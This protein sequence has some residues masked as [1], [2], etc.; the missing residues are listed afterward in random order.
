M[1]QTNLDRYGVEYA[2][3]SD[4][5]KEKVKQTNIKKY[6]V[7]Y[8][9]QSGEIKEKMKQT[10][11]DRYG[12]EN[13]SQ[14]SDI[15]KKKVQTCIGNYGVEN[16][17]QS[18][19]I[20]QKKVQTCIDKYGY[21]NYSHTRLSEDILSK[22]NNHAWLMEQYESGG[23]KFISNELGISI[24]T[25]NV[26]LRETSLKRSGSSFEI[27]IRSF[28]ESLGISNIVTND[29]KILEG[30]E[31]DIYL[32]DQKI[33]IECNGSYWHSELQ[34]KPRQYHIEKTKI[35]KSEGIHLIHIWH[36]DWISNEELIKS[37][38]KSK[39]GCNK[40]VYARKCIISAITAKGATEFMQ[41]NHIQGS[42]PGSAR[43][44]LFYD[45]E[46][47]AL[48]T[49]GKSRYKKDVEYELLRYCSKQGINVVGG[50]SKLFR[51][52]IQWYEPK[53]I[54]SYSDRM[55]N[56]G[57]LYEQLGFVHSHSTDPAY[58]YT[59]DYLHFE[60]RVAY[61]K[62]KLEA[63]LDVFDPNLTEWENMQ[64]NGFDRIWDCGNDVWVWKD[65]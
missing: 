64:A 10:N 34:G 7:E 65:K 23:T 16:P 55:W 8:P 46:L 49:F 28:I 26:Y 50:A 11:L 63:K 15:K 39:I 56:T 19:D 62:H 37:R 43:Y 41:A 57:G 21:M 53:S 60:N 17:S 29:R 42:C 13:P 25:A 35:C 51:R 6:G 2:S 38:I 18:E 40:R 20:K 44:G 24:N 59:I 5:V 30:K 45:Q 48:M 32:P 4:E 36:H 3:Q 14:S 9:S 12:V 1:K 54:I 58:H 33:A 47:L 31:L 61:Q 22:L 52:F 27:E